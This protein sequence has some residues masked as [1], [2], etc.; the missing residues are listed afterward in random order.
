MYA[1]VSRLLQ[2][3]AVSITSAPVVG[4]LCV[5]ASLGAG[6]A[7][8]PP[9]TH[10]TPPLDARD[11]SATLVFQWAPSSCDAAGYYALV[12]GEGRFLGTLG[13]GTRLYVSLASGP[14]EVIAWNPVMESEASRVAVLTRIDMSPGMRHFVLLTSGELVERG[15]QRTVVRRG[16]AR[17]C[18]GDA[19]VLQ[20]IPEQ[21]CGPEC[22]GAELESLWPD[23]EA[24]QRWLDAE[25]DFALHR[26]RARSWFSRLSPEVRRMVVLSRDE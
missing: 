6:C 9:F 2:T 12:T 17:R 8:R 25:G 21:A 26:D 16:P 3:V 19:I 18:P 24:G 13:R 15:A 14:V 22:E 1:R 10:P 23:R 4:V 5:A 11:G 20:P 7:A